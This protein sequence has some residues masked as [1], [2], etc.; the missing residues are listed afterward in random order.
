[1]TQCSPDL[2]PRL[3]VGDNNV[4][5]GANCLDPEPSGDSHPM[6]IKLR[7]FITQSRKD[8]KEVKIKA[9]MKGKYTLPNGPKF[10][11]LPAPPRLCETIK[12]GGFA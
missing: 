11:K 2:H 8:A 12:Y 9:I 3:A 10:E 7:N 1:M 6:R 5:C 4:W